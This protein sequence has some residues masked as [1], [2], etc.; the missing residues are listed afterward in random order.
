MQWRA[1]ILAA[2]LLSCVGMADASAQ[3]V[4]SALYG[5]GAYSAYGTDGLRGSFGNGNR[6]YEGR[7]AG[8]GEGPRQRADTPSPAGLCAAT[9][10]QVH[11][12]ERVLRGHGA[13]IDS[14]VIERGPSVLQRGGTIIIDLQTPE[15]RRAVD[16]AIRFLED[17]R[18]GESREQVERL[19]NDEVTPALLRLSA[20]DGRG[21]MVRNAE[22][23]A[24]TNAWSYAANLRFH[25]AVCGDYLAGSAE[26]R[27]EAAPGQTQPSSDREAE[28]AREL[29]EIEAAIMAAEARTA[30]AEARAEAALGQSRPASDREAEVARELAELEAAIAAAEAEIQEAEALAAAAEAQAAT[31]LG[32][33]QSLSDSQERSE[34]E[35]AIALAEAEARALEAEA[36]AAAAEARV[37]E[38]AETAEDAIEE[39]ESAAQSI[40]RDPSLRTAFHSRSW[41]RTGTGLGLIAAG[42]MLALKVACSPTFSEMVRDP[43]ATSNTRYQYFFFGPVDVRV[44]D[45]TDWLWSQCK[46]TPV[47]YQMGVMNNGR[48]WDNRWSL[49]EI[50]SHF[51]RH[52][53]SV[54]ESDFFP[55]GKAH[56]DASA[57]GAMRKLFLGFGM[58]GVGTLLATIWADVPDVDLTASITP[59]GG[60]LLS[61]SFGW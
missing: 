49:S 37:A 11:E 8:F 24:A 47:S 55:Y 57:D 13:V 33:T 9:R 58:I 52:G 22:L 14:M 7:P 56:F 10:M 32:Q 42:A 36:R 1:L 25:W 6:T 53:A 31:E 21:D 51:A 5:G 4:D 41:G 44:S 50:Q 39:A 18:P 45:S 20:V 61:R 46:N 16:A 60:V 59:G 23:S 15:A 19:V 35:A 3:T 48:M 43:R 29:A 2:V 28:A 12:F 30:S 27:A 54:D 38:I 17:S 26:A 34:I 40:V